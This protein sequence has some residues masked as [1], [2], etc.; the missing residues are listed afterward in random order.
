MLKSKE[1]GDIVFRRMGSWRQSLLQGVEAR[2]PIV[3][4]FHKPCCGSLPTRL[5]VENI[6]T[7]SSV[8][9]LR[10]Q[11]QWEDFHNKSSG[12]TSMTRLVQSMA[13]TKLVGNIATTTFLGTIVPE[14]HQI[15][16]LLF[17]FNLKMLKNNANSTLCS[18]LL[19][20]LTILSFAV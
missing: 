9:R 19:L 8:G 7:T 1:C 5:V 3:G 6:A 13:T 18:L 12:K 2:F 14:L 10:K 20:W 17:S 16:P 4:Q 11:V 15:S